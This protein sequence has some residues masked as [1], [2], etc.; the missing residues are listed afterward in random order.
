MRIVDGSEQES[1]LKFF[2]NDWFRR[3]H[4]S[5]CCLQLTAEPKTWLKVV[6]QKKTGFYKGC[7][8]IKLCKISFWIR[9]L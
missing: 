9:K 4:G 3:L 5:K 6:L 7:N 1:I 8:N 2:K